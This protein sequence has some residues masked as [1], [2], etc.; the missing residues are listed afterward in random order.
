VQEVFAG[1][2]IRARETLFEPDFAD[3]GAI[4]DPIIPWMEIETSPR[5]P[6]KPGAGIFDRDDTLL[7]GNALVSRTWL[8]GARHNRGLPI[9]PAI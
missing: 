5:F 3:G 7:S 9:I 2:R 1:R 4:P 6:R 8:R